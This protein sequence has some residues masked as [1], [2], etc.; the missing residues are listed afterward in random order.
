MSHRQVSIVSSTE[1]PYA[2]RTHLDLVPNLVTSVSDT[3]EQS[4]PIP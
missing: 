1:V 3:P 2:P 4:Q